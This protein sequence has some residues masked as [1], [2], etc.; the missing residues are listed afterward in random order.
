MPFRI[1]VIIQQSF[2][3]P[4]AVEVDASRRDYADQ[5][6]AE[7]AKQC[8]ETF[9][10]IYRAQYLKCLFEVDCASTKGREECGS[11][12]KWIRSMKLSELCL[13]EIGLEAG[14]ENV[15]RTCQS[16]SGH[17][18]EAVMVSVEEIMR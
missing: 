12:W 13:V 2:S 4:I 11:L 6:C 3:I 5:V 16:R 7:T 18:T 10:R 9:M 8:A 15:K 17:T 14:F 1:K